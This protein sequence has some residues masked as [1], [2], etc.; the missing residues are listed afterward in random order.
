VPGAAT[1]TVAFSDDGGV[2]SITGCG[3]QPVSSGGA[4]CTIT[5]GYAAVGTHSITAIYS[6]DGN[7]TGSTS[8]PLT[9]TTAAVVPP[10]PV[11][12]ALPLITGTAQQGATLTADH[13]SWTTTDPTTYAYQWQDCT[14]GTCTDTGATNSTYTLQS[15]DVGDTIKVVVTATNAA[16]PTAATSA[17]TLAVLDATPTSNPDSPP[18]I[19]G[20]AKVSQ[21][22]TVNTT[23]AFAGAN[24][25]YT[26]QWQDCTDARCTNVASG[27]TSSSYTLQSGDVGDTIE[28][29]VTATNDGG[30]SPATSL[31]TT[32]V[33][34]LPNPTPT[35]TPPQTPTPTP[36]PAP[37]ST[38]APVISGT[39][40]VGH[41]L[42]VSTGSWS[43]NTTGFRHQWLRDGIPIPGATH[44]TYTVQTADQGHALTCTVTASDASS[45]TTTTSSSTSPG[46]T[47]P[48][49][50]V[51]A[52]PQPS[53]QLSGTTLGPIT[54]GLTRTR[55]RRTL[56]RF[57]PRSYHTDNFCLSGGWGIRVG[58]ASARLLG[59]THTRQ[60]AISGRVVLALTANP[61]Y[62]LDEVK[63]GTRLV[64]AAHRL[65]LGK[66][67]QL[68]VNDWYVI[69][70]ATSNGVLKV[71][72]GIIQEI[73]I[74]NKRL[75]ATRAAQTR[76][77]ISF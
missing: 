9:Q 30:S 65:K 18:T 1:G 54:L 59:S 62:T 38:A 74:T 53:G 36:T 33:A 27:G 23:G 2:S 6:G 5:G 73:G 3:S 16:G 7:Y 69:P 42:S 68:G 4:S 71:R 21:T 56:P 51:Q 41:V 72:H 40:A 12:T 13:G 64:G 11:N 22:L 58:Y 46:V 34:A 25:T 61:F 75:T 50:N 35:P 49:N 17:A 48:I 15:T 24:V 47:I 10:D 67:I 31:Q 44:S 55:A 20:T 14:G 60:A 37:V 76:L 63:P 43:A 57:K 66:V 26:Y 39:D 77:L 8:S 52:C 19:S 29:V 70:G 32:A 45:T 28:V